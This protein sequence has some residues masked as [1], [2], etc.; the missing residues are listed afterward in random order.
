MVSDYRYKPQVYFAATF[1]VTYAFWFA[2]A[3]LSFQDDKNGLYLLFTLLGLVVPFLIS[4]FMIFTSKNSNLKREFINR[5]IN[6]RLIKPR[7]LPLFFL[8]MPITVIISILLSLPFG[9]SISQF[10]LANGFSFST[11]SI[12]VLIFLMLTA[13][14]EELGWRGYAFDSLQSRYTYFTASVIFSILWSL[15]HFPL[16]F[17][18]HFYQYEIYHEN[19]WYA[20]N[21]FVGIIPMGVFVSWVCIKNGKSIPAAILF[22]FII[23]IFQEA[24]NMTQTTKCIETLVITVIIA[25]IIVLDKEMFFSKVSPIPETQNLAPGTQNPVYEAH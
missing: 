21:F 5:L 2:G 25:I 11:G 1:I 15:W 9:G 13:C 7:M 10:Q 14:F 17:V 4:H 24:L 16:I 18:N 6:L 22:H 3:Y 12:P 23:N 19:I 8:I 20:V